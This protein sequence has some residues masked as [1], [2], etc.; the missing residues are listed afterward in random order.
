MVSPVDNPSVY[1]DLAGLNDISKLGR[2][3]TPEGLRQVAKQFE[4]MFLNIMLK[5]M[6]NS[7]K[8]FSEGNYLQSNEMEFHQQNF[9]N[10]LSLHLSEGAGIGLADVL[11][12]Q[13]M[14]Q[15]GVSKEQAG[16]RNIES[17]LPPRSPIPAVKPL[18]SL[19]P[20][21]THS[22]HLSAPVST[23]E[24]Y[25][26]SAMPIEALRTALQARSQEQQR[27]SSAGV[28]S[29]IP[30]A[31]EKVEINSPK[32]FVE[33]L[34][35]AAQRVA[36][37]I[38][39]DPKLLLAQSA[40]ETGWGKRMITRTDGGNSHNLFGI[41]ADSRWSGERATVMTT[42]FENGVVRKE[43]ANFRAYNSYEESFKDYVDFLKSN[44][45]YQQA[46]ENS[47]DPEAFAKHLQEAGYATDPVYARKI[48]RVM[49]SNTMSLALRDV[50]NKV[51]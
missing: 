12:E 19:E 29:A 51:L 11:Y 15:F 32:D 2:E 28:G 40:L 36:E 18:T 16:Q 38:G 30:R 26:N 46:L 3:N 49:N 44:P 22:A 5:E 50:Q 17:T 7:T 39:V 37:S 27:N 1:T 43:Q 24:G 20:M 45:R 13:M 48:S 35:P 6:R 47:H 42:E 4:S 10:Q 34:Y 14:G 25:L 41:K 8:A 33:A 23:D 21:V 31:A 9:D